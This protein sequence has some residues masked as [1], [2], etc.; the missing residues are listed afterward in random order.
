MDRGDHLRA[1]PRHPHH[2]HHHVRPRRAARALGAPHGPA[3]RHPE[4]DGRLHRVRPAVAHPP[5]GA[6]VPARPRPGRAPG[7]HRAR[8]DQD[9]RARAPHARPH[10]PQHPVLVGEGRA[11]SSPSTCSPAAP[12]TSAARS[13]TSRSPRRRARATASSCRRPSCA[14]SSATPAA[15]RPARHDRTSCSRSTRRRPTTTTRRSTTSTDAEA[16]FG[17][18]RRLTASGQFRFVHPNARRATDRLRAARIRLLSA[19]AGLS[20]IG[21]W[22]HATVSSAR[23]YRSLSTQRRRDASWQNR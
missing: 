22:L 14:A 11:R 3:A 7:R 8:G 17:S 21:P 20:R 18:Y 6:D 1:R 15:S 13:S 4:A 16:R 12:T 9:A 19:R 5:R 10:L 23:P 2:V